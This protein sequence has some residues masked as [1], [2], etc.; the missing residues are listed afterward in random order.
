LRSLAKCVTTVSGNWI[1][2]DT[3]SILLGLDMLATGKGNPTLLL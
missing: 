2:P 3:V 1:E